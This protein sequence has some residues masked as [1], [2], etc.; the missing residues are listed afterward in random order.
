MFILRDGNPQQ[1]KH[2]AASELTDR[3][4]NRS[5]DRRQYA[6]LYTLNRVDAARTVRAE[7]KQ[8]GSR[9]KHYTGDKSTTLL[10]GLAET[11]AVDI[12][13]RFPQISS[14]QTAKFL[15]S[16]ASF[17]SFLLTRKGPKG[18]RYLH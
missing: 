13:P 2:C 6:P 12:D 1:R 8:R 15:S 16:T 5:V 3:T 17:F 14:L 18:P 4:S 9:D 7:A 11:V 10:G